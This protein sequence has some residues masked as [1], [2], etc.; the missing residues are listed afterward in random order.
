MKGDARDFEHVGYKSND[1]LLEEAMLVWSRMDHDL[2]YG[3][4]TRVRVIRH[5]DEYNE[6]GHLRY[7]TGACWAYW[8]GLDQAAR[9]HRL[10]IDA[11]HIVVQ[12]GLPPADVHN[13]LLVIPEYR[14][15]LSSGFG[16]YSGG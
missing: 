8:R 10:M 5:P 1:I 6:Q 15:L 16:I 12:D 9:I 3:E 14:H 2:R 11:W 13:A 4:T 7:S